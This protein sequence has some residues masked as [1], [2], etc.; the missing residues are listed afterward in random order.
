M[1][2]HC[3]GCLITLLVT[4]LPAL[5]D[6]Q[7]GANAAR[8]AKV[9]TVVASSSTLQRVYPAIVFPSQEV[10]LSFRVSGRLVELPIKA[11]DIVAQDGIIARLD[12]RDFEAEVRRLKSQLDQA[13]AQL[14]VLRTGARPEEIASLE[15]SVAAASAQLDQAKEEYERTQKL[16]EREVVSTAQLQQREAAFRVAEA[17][18]DTRIEQLAI[19]RSGGRPEEILAAEASIRGLE[20]QIQSA[21]DN[22]SDATLRAPFAGTIAR[23]FVENFR[24]VQAG[25]SIA[26]IQNL[27]TVEIGYD[28]PGADIVAMSSIGFDEIE[29]VVV[30]EAM[31][32][33]E[34]Q[35]D[36]VEFSTQ[37]DAATQ[38]YRGRLSVTPPEGMVVLPGMVARVIIR[39]AAEPEPKLT[40]PLSAL[41][42]AP[43]GSPFVWQVNVSDNTVSRQPVDLGSVSKD[44]AI[45]NAG[46]SAGAM[47]VTAGLSGLQ[48]G[49]TIRPVTKIGD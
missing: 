17:E 19:G 48:D 44:G 11:S 25:E 20:T 10:E 49:M 15:A 33:V 32:D 34:V 43:D 29:S 14:I 22:V 5:A 21:R 8:P 12:T 39:A 1:R 35:A 36:L 13:Q 37:A 40:V 18:L 6:T 41:D 2:L 47:V 3:I 4:S 28:L 42:S 9:H 30:F 24:N 45:V 38:T 26:L 46:L 7:N 31:R 23:R 27:D 16:V